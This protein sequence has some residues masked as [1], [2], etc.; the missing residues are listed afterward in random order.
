[1]SD[2]QM[3]RGLNG[4]D[5]RLGKYDIPFL[6]AARCSMCGTAACVRTQP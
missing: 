3:F 5:E 6:G 4:A 2:R 1:M